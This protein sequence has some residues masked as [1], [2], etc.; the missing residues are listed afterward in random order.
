[1][2]CKQPAGELAKPVELLN[3]GR[4]SS[5]PHGGS[6]SQHVRSFLT[7]LSVIQHTQL[8][9]NHLMLLLLPPQPQDP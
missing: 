4:V 6:S 9:A 7:W 1:L 5:P 8:A 3:S 2:T